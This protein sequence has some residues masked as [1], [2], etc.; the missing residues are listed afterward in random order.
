MYFALPSAGT[1][2]S[3]RS[4]SSNHAAIA[5]NNNSRA[6]I[7][8][9]SDSASN[10]PAHG[11][12]GKSSPFCI[13]GVAGPTTAG[14]L[15][16]PIIPV[17]S[18]SNNSRDNDSCMASSRSSSQ[19][20]CTSSSSSSSFHSERNTHQQ[21][22][23]N[24]NNRSKQTSSSSCTNPGPLFSLSPTSAATS[25]STGST[26]TPATHSSTGANTCSS[27]STTGSMPPLFALAPSSF[28]T[29]A[30]SNSNAM[31]VDEQQQQQEEEQT[32]TTSLSLTQEQQET[33][34][35]VT[36]LS[37]RMTGLPVA[38][39]TSCRSGQHQIV[40]QY[41][42]DRSSWSQEQVLQTLQQQQPPSSSTSIPPIFYQHLP[43]SLQQEQA[44]ERPAVLGTL[45]LLGSQPLSPLTGEEQQ[46]LE[47]LAF[48]ATQALQQAMTQPSSPSSNCH[49]RKVSSHCSEN[50]PSQMP[51]QMQ[52]PTS[53]DT[54]NRAVV[55][56]NMSNSTTPGAL[57]SH[58][59]EEHIRRPTRNS[60]SV[61]ALSQSSSSRRRNSFRRTLSKESNGSVEGASSSSLGW[62]YYNTPSSAADEDESQCIIA[63]TAH[64]LLTPLMGLQLSLSLLQED[65]KFVQ[66]L[67]EQPLQRESF[68][69]AWQSTEVMF[70]MCQTTIDTLR[71]NKQ[72]RRDEHDEHDDDEHA[73][74]HSAQSPV[75]VSNTTPHK[76]THSN[77]H[78]HSSHA[79]NA[80]SSTT[81]TTTAL[82]TS[83]PQSH[84]VAT[85][86]CRLD[87]T[88]LLQSL[89]R[90]MDP[91]PKRVPL[92]MTLTSRVPNQVPVIATAA[93]AGAATTT[94]PGDVANSDTVDWRI[95][96]C[97]MTIL[98]HAC[99]VS[100]SASNMQQQRKPIQ[101]RINVSSS[102][103]RSSSNNIKG[104]SRSSSKSSATGKNRYRLVVECEHDC[105]DMDMDMDNLFAAAAASRGGGGGAEAY[106]SL[107]SAHTLA[108]KSIAYQM[109]SVYG[110]QHGFRRPLM[111]QSRAIFWFSVPVSSSFSDTTS[112]SSS[113][114]SPSTPMQDRSIT[115][116]PT[117]EDAPSVVPKGHRPTVSRIMSSLPTIHDD[118]IVR[119]MNAG[120]SKSGTTTAHGNTP[121]VVGLN[122]GMKRLRRS[123]TGSTNTLNGRRRTFSDMIGLLR[124][125]KGL[126]G[127][128]SVNALSAM[129]SHCH[130]SQSSNHNWNVGKCSDGGP[131]QAKFYKQQNFQYRD[132]AAS[133]MAA[134]NAI[135]SAFRLS[136]GMDD[137]EKRR[138]MSYSIIQE[139]QRMQDSETA[140]PLFGI[141]NSTAPTTNKKSKTS[142]STA[143]LD[144]C[145]QDIMGN[146]KGYCSIASSSKAERV[147]ER[148]LWNG[149]S[150]SSKASLALPRPVSSSSTAIVGRKGLVID[151]S[152]V[153]RKTVARALTKLGVDT[154]VQACDGV[155]GV[156]RMKEEAFEVTL[157][158]F[159][160]PNLGGIDCVMQYRRWE[161][162]QAASGRPKQ[163]IIGMS[164]HASTTDIAQGTK[165]GMN[166]Y[167]PKPLTI[168]LLG[169]LLESAEVCE[170]RSKL[171]VWQRGDS[172]EQAA[173][174]SSAPVNNE[175]GRLFAN[176]TAPTVGFVTASQSGS[177]S[178]VDGSM[179]KR[180]KMEPLFSMATH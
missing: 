22:M 71:A 103:S 74:L 87:L 119:M 23:M 67:E 112:S 57:H 32:Y 13:G 6:P 108:L 145:L 61:S 16:I 7:S 90:L 63:C 15:P 75:D 143:G 93:T 66:H 52:S 89:Q 101:L 126:A 178:P 1:S 34:N 156:Q 76:N 161:E 85:Q 28:E 84:R 164:A 54:Q 133:A 69:T 155:E 9:G 25:T 82:A 170:M 122:S 148:L 79:P 96:R 60:L 154:V 141:M 113:T 165:V 27:S 147:R 33:L 77:S 55:D 31:Q 53:E 37:T 14:G 29:E 99:H 180:P 177:D 73:L 4:N 11:G 104:G 174:T 142:M 42:L 94:T 48:L 102:G 153:I 21:S 129:F 100:S 139:E 135:S 111:D 98:A 59:A 107:S 17:D 30:A 105:P 45:S 140:K 88:V 115:L 46:D 97:A 64:D 131:Q 2:T 10:S 120:S 68:W 70:R 136:A 166:G 134:Q 124:D 149:N 109:E 20:S 118:E 91:I 39:I 80:A 56:A 92:V 44:A 152:L 130:P 12:Q 128:P 51:M 175:E 114:A 40:A 121:L 81:T 62:N 36:R 116:N 5:G 106:S 169:G 151:D 19:S 179:M 168:K 26:G 35:R 144:R 173:S 8:T 43:L 163:Y 132:S 95:L 18:S 171:D 83:H 117:P 86:I 162:E 49:R 160:M 47:D 137:G 146:S 138:N 110:G 41:G 3:T 123:S 172:A 125:K 127:A 58:P 38:M 158:D 78:N 176:I 72:N 150:D 50:T 167:L 24:N 65:P 157:C 159:S